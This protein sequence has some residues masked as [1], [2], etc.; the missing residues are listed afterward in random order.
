MTKT[1]AD[2]GIEV[3]AG[4]GHTRALCPQ[5]SRQRKKQYI[6]DLSVDL[7]NGVWFCHHC[8]WTGGLGD[9]D[10]EAVKKHFVKPHFVEADVDD[11]ARAWFEQRGISSQTLAAMKIKSGPAWMHGADGGGIVNTVQFPF[12]MGGEVVNVKYRT[13]DKRFRQEKNARKCFYNFDGALRSNSETLVIT[14]GEMDCLSVIESGHN[15]SLSVPDGAPNADAK[16][17]TSKFDF[18]EGAEELLS[19]FARIVLYVDSDPNGKKLEEELARRIGVERCYRVTHPAGC[20]D[21]NDVLVK[22]GKQHLRQVI[23]TAKPFPVEGVKSVA[24]LYDAVSDLK[25]SGVKKAGVDIGWPLY[26]NILN[27]ELGQMT[28]V[29]GIPSHGKSTWVDALR[30]NLFRIHGWASAACSPENWPAEDHLALLLEM[31]ATKNFYEMTP[32][33]FESAIDDVRSGFHFIQPDSEVDMMTIDDILTCAK[34]LIFRH[35]IKILVID[36]WNEIKHTLEAGEREDQYISRQLAKIRRFARMNRIHIFVIAHP[37]K[38]EKNKNGGYP[39]PTPY[40]IAGGAMWRNKADI[41]LC[42][43]RPD[44]KTGRTDV[45]VQKVRYRRN[46]KVDK[47]EFNF[48]VD[49]STYY[50]KGDGVEQQF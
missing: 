2:F 10:R 35:G 26:S 13:G 40:D 34:S 28:I 18:L 4:S 17:Y 49:T 46:G 33:E 44:M 16:T 30:V 37:T 12:Y 47:M 24:D 9:F 27:I 32:D 14:E 36:P 19:K 41:A 38:L 25:Y 48:H 29:T 39:I 7:D 15:A 11:K 21:A 43:H 3:D 50:E 31:Y 23:D 22:H 42:V 1:F 8:G 5:C 45:Y 6:K 20:K